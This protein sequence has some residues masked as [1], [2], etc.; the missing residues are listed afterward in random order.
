MTAMLI[1]VSIEHHAKGIQNG[2]GRASEETGMHRAHL[3]F[4]HRRHGESSEAAS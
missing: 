4:R 1:Q 3:S 2:F